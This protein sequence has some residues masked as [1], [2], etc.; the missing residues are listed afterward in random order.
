MA[1]QQALTAEQQARRSEREAA[2]SEREA[3]KVYLDS[4]AEQIR[5]ETAELDA[6]VEELTSVL[7]STLAVDDFLDF[8]SLRQAVAAAPFQ[9][10]AL[11]TPEPQPTLFVPP[12]IPP[13]P[14]EN[15]PLS[16]GAGLV[17]GRRAKHE[18]EVAESERQHR[19]D[20]EAARRVWEGEK[21]RREEAHQGDMVAWAERDGE[22][23]RRLEAARSAYEDETARHLDAIETANREVDEFKR[24]FEAREPQ[25][26]VEYFSLVL[27]NSLYPEGFYHRVD[28]GYIPESQTLI[29]EKLI[30]GPLIVPPVK[31]VKYVRSRDE[32]TEQPRSDSD[33]KRIYNQILCQI[34]LRSIHEVLEADRSEALQS[35]EFSGF[36]L[37]VDPAS[38]LD[39]KRYIVAA[40]AERSHFLE[41]N[42]VAVDP[43]ECV[44]AL[45]GKLSAKP[46]EGS[47][48]KVAHQVSELDPELVVL[49]EG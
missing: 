44:K 35:V 37:G 9:P 42:L 14:P 2:R 47:P 7:T 17:P 32:R 48:V 15:A 11:G 46:L 3:Q 31:S 25:A 20:V 28:V 29:I 36:V 13:P 45:G 23:V 33:R 4:R 18:A 10:G 26:V 41:L 38:G 12:F 24:G 43:T 40:T 27:D 8:E 34:A 49:G 39:S 6:Q 16:R 1:A 22:R 21:A 30:P 19:D 5:S